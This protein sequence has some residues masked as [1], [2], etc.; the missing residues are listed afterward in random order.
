MQAVDAEDPAEA[1]AILSG[2]ARMDAY[3]RGA[4]ENLYPELPALQETVWMLAEGERA[5]ETEIEVF[6]SLDLLQK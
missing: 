5:A 2:L 1:S 6:I 3:V 4:V